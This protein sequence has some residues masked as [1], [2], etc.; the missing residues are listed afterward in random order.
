MWCEEREANVIRF[1]SSP[2]ASLSALCLFLNI[3]TTPNR[4][5]H[6]SGMIPTLWCTV[7]WLLSPLSVPL[8]PPCHSGPATCLHA[9]CYMGANHQ[10][11]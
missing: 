7:L 4:H 5:H 3:I 11:V 10:G 6:Y 8:S 9:S 1:S 2:H